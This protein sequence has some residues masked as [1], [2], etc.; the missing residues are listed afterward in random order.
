VDNSVVSFIEAHAALIGLIGPICTAIAAV[1]GIFL[2]W[3]NITKTKLEISRLHQ[4]IEAGF[5]PALPGTTSFFNSGITK[6]IIMIFADLLS[7]YIIVYILE[8]ALE[9]FLPDTIPD[10]GFFQT[11]WML[12]HL[13]IFGTVAFLYWPIFLSIR[14]LR[15]DVLGE[16]RPTQLKP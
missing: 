12:R 3:T 1:F 11:R 2:A 14:Q 16:S 13:I 9:L 10:F 15:A 6:L 8:V 7:A 5:T 4:Q